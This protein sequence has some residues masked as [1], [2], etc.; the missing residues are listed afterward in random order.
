MENPSLEYASTLKR[1]PR[2][3]VIKTITEDLEDL[4]SDLPKKEEL[5][6][7]ERGRLTQAAAAMLRARIASWTATGYRSKLD[8]AHH[9][10]RIRSL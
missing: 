8:Q 7:D 1:T 3:E 10:R 4:I 6:V 2:A 9:R 5:P